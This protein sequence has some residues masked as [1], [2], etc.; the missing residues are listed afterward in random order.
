MKKVLTVGV[1][2]E[3]ATGMALLIL[4]PSLVEATGQIGSMRYGL[5][6]AYVNRRSH[7]KSVLV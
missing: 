4:L 6:V 3:V 1:V 2:A 5:T 7:A